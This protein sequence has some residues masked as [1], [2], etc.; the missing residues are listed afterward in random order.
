M[1]VLLDTHAFLWWISDDE[2]LTAGARETIGAADNQVFVS[3]ASVWEI[4]TKSRLGRLPL[5]EPVGRFVATHLEQNAFQPLPIAMRH[6]FELETLPDLHRDP[7]DRMLV[8]QA[9]AEEMPLV[10]GDDAVRAYPLTTI[11]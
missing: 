2:Q 3:V 10:S 6:A 7:F 5:P 8:A 9:L 11:W 1:R 4:V